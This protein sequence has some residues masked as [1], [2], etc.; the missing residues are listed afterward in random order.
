MSAPP[1]LTAGFRPAGPSG[2]GGGHPRPH[3]VKPPK[4]SRGSGAASRALLFLLKWGLVAAIWGCAALAVVLAYYCYDLPDVRQVAQH[5][6]RPAVTLLAADGTRFSR[7]GELQG[8]IIEARRLPPHMVNAVLAIEDRRFYSHFG[9][10]LIGL[11][12]AVAVNLRH[13]HVQGGSTLTQQ[14]AK[15]LFLSGERTLKRKVQE[16]LLA[17]W[18]EHLY[19]KDQILTAYLNRVYLGS[20]VYGVDAAAQT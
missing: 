18:L 9:I 15:N 4:A 1:P 10:D 6:R 8:A 12:R 3:P 11:A 20:G 13:R 19:S 17:L 16:A 7:T 5:T 14:L 2:K